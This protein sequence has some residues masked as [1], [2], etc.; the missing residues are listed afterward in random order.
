MPRLRRGGKRDRVE[1]ALR[2]ARGNQPVPSVP[3]VRRRG[4]ARASTIDGMSR[5][6]RVLALVT[7]GASTLYLAGTVV[8]WLTPG[9]WGVMWLLPLAVLSA[10]LLR[11]LERPFER[12]AT[13]RAQGR[14]ERCEYDLRA[15]PYRCPEC[16]RTT[17]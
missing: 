3:S 11:L 7:V 14:C 12:R 2:K 8:L 5:K 16:G 9:P 17:W 15:T 10:A 13:L 1:S 6:W 4:P